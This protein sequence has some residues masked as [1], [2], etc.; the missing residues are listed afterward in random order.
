MVF[1]LWL[2]LNSPFTKGSQPA[3]YCHCVPRINRDNSFPLS[4]YSVEMTENSSGMVSLFSPSSIVTGT[5]S[6]VPREWDLLATPLS[7]V[8]MGYG[9]GRLGWDSSHSC[10]KIFMSC[11]TSVDT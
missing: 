6:T 1:P 10:P 5:L 9:R 4:S 7:S 3:R 11:P 2:A 8:V